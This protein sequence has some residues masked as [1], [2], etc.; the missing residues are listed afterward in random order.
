MALL[1]RWQAFIAFLAGNP[2]GGVLTTHRAEKRFLHYEASFYAGLNFFGHHAL[3]FAHHSESCLVK[4]CGVALSSNSL[5]VLHCNK[6]GGPKAA[7]AS[8]IA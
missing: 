2:P 7:L 5:L 4:K 8:L 1:R 3:V 6:K